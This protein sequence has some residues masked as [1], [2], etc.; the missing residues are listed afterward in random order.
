MTDYK[1]SVVFSTRKIDDNFIEHL[2]K[3]CMYKGVE[4]LP[5]ENN[6]EYSLTQIYN[7]GLAEASSNIVVFCHDDIVFETNSWGEKILK[8]FD[9]NPEYGIL[10]VAGTNHMISGMWWEIRNAM[11]GTVKHTDGTKVWTNKY[12]TNYG[13]QIKE[14]VVVDGLFIAVNK[15]KIKHSFDET[16]DGFHF[17]D[18]S[19]CLKN[20]LDGVKIGLVSNVLLLHKSVGAVN[21]KWAS[22]KAKFESMYLDKLPICLNENVKHIIF[23][24]DIPKVE[25]HVLCWNE[26][27]IIPYFLN[28]YENLVTNIFVYDNKS[29]DDTVKLLK[30]HPKVTIIPYDTNGEIRDDAYL[31]IKNTAWKNSVNRADIVI[32][33]DMD[34][35]L[36]SDDLKSTIIEFNN[37]EATIVKPT[38]YDMIVDEFTFDY[39]NKLTDLVK[40]G[41]RNDLFDKFLM[42]KPKSVVEINYKGGCHFA[43]PSGEVILFENKFLLLHYK[44][45]GLKYYLNRMRSY[46]NRLSNF[47]KQYKLGYE[48]GFDENKHVENFAENLD[49]IQSVI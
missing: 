2:K 17:Y 24:K 42:F 35:F 13:N 6:G 4:V 33:C 44:R 48:Y 32:V 40:T 43:N 29:T 25:M 10:G 3:T 46:K 39:E 34:E 36:Y 37:S 21:D 16:F 26:E 5:Y 47:N 30:A 49:K 23:D 14:M 19:F 9:K 45:L 8:A 28:H 41:V 20:Y 11:H 15:E 1:I 31:Q 7:K 12:S 22:N 27:K 38:G 18:I